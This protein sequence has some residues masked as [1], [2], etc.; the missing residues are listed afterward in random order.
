ME[1]IFNKLNISFLLILLY[2]LSMIIFSLDGLSISKLAITGFVWISVF[3]FFH[4]FVKN[5]RKLKNNIPRFAFN[6]LWLL[7]FW[8]IINIGRGLISDDGTITTLFG[9]VYTSLALLV[10]FVIIFSMNSLNIQRINRYFFN[11]LKI[12]ML[13]F[14]LYFVFGGVV[15]NFIQIRILYSLFL[16]VVFLITT[17]PFE[18]RK[19]KLIILIGG[20]LLLYLSILNS[21]RTM[22]IR[23]LLLIAVLIPF[24]YYRIFHFKWILKGS[25]MLLLVPLILLQSSINTGD[26]FIQKSLNTISDEEMSVDT[27]TFLYIEVLE[28]LTKNKKLLFGK[29]ANGTYYSDYFSITRGDTDTR[30][31]VEVGVLAIMLKTGLIG[32][33]LY[34]LLLFIAIYYAFFR[35]NNDYVV[36]IGL[37]LF[38]YVILLFIENSILYSSHNVFVWF[39]V[40]VCLSNQ[41]RTMSNFEIHKI[42][43]PKKAH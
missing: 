13:L 21:M 16:P 5:Y 23:E 28:D 39:F 15:F 12:G 25:F 18:K 38:I 4:D 10:P 11:L 24:Y 32:F 3:I 20:I 6:I 17:I 41:I 36:G 37:M 2:E 27:R 26:S 30:L 42:L 40:G 34:L 33:T 7:L 1:K 31:S 35:S 14:I 8:N 9:N 29:G 22:L 19:K 43:N